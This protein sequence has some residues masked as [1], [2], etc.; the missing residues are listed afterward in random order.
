MTRLLLWVIVITVAVMVLSE[1]GLV[2]MEGVP[3]DF[4]EWFAPSQEE[5][6]VKEKA[7][8]E[9]KVARKEQVRLQT[10]EIRVIKLE[11]GQ[12]VRVPVGEKYEFDCH[13]GEFYFSLL[14]KGQQMKTGYFKPGFMMNTSSIQVDEIEFHQHPQYPYGDLDIRLTLATAE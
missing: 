10:P 6:L 14:Y 3:T 9:T 5:I 11:P 12:T 2:K 13:N 1:Q 8:L 4:S 7:R